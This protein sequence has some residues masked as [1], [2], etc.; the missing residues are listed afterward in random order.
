[1]VRVDACLAHVELVN[2]SYARLDA[3]YTVGADR[4]LADIR[5][6]GPNFPLRR[7]AAKRILAELKS[8]KAPEL[9]ADSRKRAGPKRRTTPEL[10]RGIRDALATDPDAASSS[11][12]RLAKKYSLSQAT[13]GHAC[14]RI[15]RRV[16]RRAKTSLSQ[17]KRAHLGLGNSAANPF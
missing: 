15:P 17:R 2:A 12:R 10:T 8:G 6:R 9:I 5:E 14:A 16:K 4:V 3:T 13:V 7:D 1:M 11:Q